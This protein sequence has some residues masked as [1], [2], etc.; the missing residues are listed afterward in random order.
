M[1]Q[2]IELLKKLPKDHL[3]HFT[4]CLLVAWTAARV[5]CAVMPVG[6][7]H[8]LMSVGIGATIAVLVGVAKEL[9]DDRQEG[10]RLSRD[11][12]L[13]DVLGAIAGAA[14]TL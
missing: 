1:K 8:R 2:L 3:L 14:M 5:A 9:R 6:L 13:A 4:V 7:K 10:N 12:L 11:D